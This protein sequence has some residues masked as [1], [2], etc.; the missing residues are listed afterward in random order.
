MKCVVAYPGGDDSFRI[1]WSCHGQVMGLC[2]PSRVPSTLLWNAAAVP[3][4]PSQKH[5]TSAPWRPPQLLLWMLV[6]CPPLCPT[7]PTAV[8][9]P[10]H[11]ASSQ[12]GPRTTCSAGGPP[13]CQHWMAHFFPTVGGEKSRTKDFHT[14]FSTIQYVRN[15][16]G[17]RI[18]DFMSTFLLSYSLMSYLILC[19]ELGMWMGTRRGFCQ[20]N[21]ILL[22]LKRLTDWWVNQ[23]CKQMV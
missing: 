15:I 9:T 16:S 1:D 21:E 11:P 17:D 14:Y 5:P 18:K 13:T 20:T 8:T 2:G 10:N 19:L 7:K 6:I 3:W 22:P 23:I 4:R 12:T